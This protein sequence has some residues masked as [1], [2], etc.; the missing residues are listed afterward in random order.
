MVICRKFKHLVL[1]VL[2]QQM[3]VEGLKLYS[4]KFD[5][6][7]RYPRMSSI[8]KTSLEYDKQFYKL[9]YINDYQLI[10]PY[11]TSD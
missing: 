6:L 3:I 4:K 7:D 5:L 10:F 8:L 9:N 11:P 1:M 2:T